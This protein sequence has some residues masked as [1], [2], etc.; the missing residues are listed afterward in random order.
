MKVNLRCVFESESL[1]IAVR[2]VK[3]CGL[4]ARRLPIVALVVLNLARA[5]PVFG[6]ISGTTGAV[7]IAVPPADISNGAWESNTQIRAFSEL[8]Q[9]VLASPLPLDISVPGT[10]PGAADSNL[11]P[12]TLQ[13]GTTVNSYALHFDVVGSLPTQNAKEATGS[14]TFSDDVLGLIALSDTLNSTNAILGL[15]GV[16]YS[17]GADHGLELNPA[18]T[19]TS[20][21]VTL[22]ADRRTVTVDLQNASFP[23]DL[24]IVTAVPEP[25]SLVLAAM[26]V[27]LSILAPVR[28]I[29]CA[30]LRAGS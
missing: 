19:G 28:R 26:L 12:A 11:S 9:V 17:N 4:V 21:V 7:V 23:D 10:S 15:P 18:G 27:G 8:Q 16:I 13:A 25:S 24:R 22:S 29:R 2:L 1:R 20:D 5:C 30:K 14:I 3:R 6:A